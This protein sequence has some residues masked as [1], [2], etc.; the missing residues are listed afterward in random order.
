MATNEEELQQ[1]IAIDTPKET[2]LEELQKAPVEE[3]QTKL[4]LINTDTESDKL[5]KITITKEIFEQIRKSLQDTVKSMEKN[6]SIFSRAAEYWGE[7]PLWQKI[8]GGV[9]LTVPT[10]IIG[11]VAHIGF[12]LA[13]CGV[14]A[15]TYTAGGL[16]LDDHHKCSTSAVES[17]QKGILGLADLLELTINA[18]DIIRQQLAAEIQKFA[19]EN[20]Q[21]EEHIEQISKQ[22][23]AIDREVMATSKVNAALGETKDGLEAVSGLLKEEVTQQVDFLK[24]NQEK[25]DRITEAYNSSQKELSDRVFEVQ[26][27]RT[28]LGEDLNRAKAMIDTLHLA[29][30]QLSTSAIGNEEQRRAFQEKLDVFIKNK[31][32]SFLLIADRICDA[33]RK[34]ALVQKELENS[35][36]RYHELLKI[37]ERHIDKLQTL[38]TPPD[39]APQVTPVGELLN[40][41]GFYAVK[42]EMPLSGTEIRTSLE[43]TM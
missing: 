33:E 35:N 15:V 16:I 32:S 20:A 36:V 30:S 22:I 18:L 17:L 7:L 1:L 21:L 5:Q 23:D 41:N 13:I 25:L 3:I 10:L 6:P 42:Q 24:Q 11:I 40:K 4:Q 38:S 27:V 12:L 19:K 31:E 37:Q 8:I 14:T 2:E 9:A 34:L 43:A 39:Q 26:K 28:E 29:I